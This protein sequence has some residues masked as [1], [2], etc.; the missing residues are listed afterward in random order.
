M[1]P[2]SPTPEQTAPPRPSTS[3][4][5][6]SN[7]RV[8][9]EPDP[10]VRTRKAAVEDTLAEVVLLMPVVQPGV[11]ASVNFAS[12]S[13]AKLLTLIQAAERP[14]GKEEL[15]NALAAAFGSPSLLNASFCFPGLRPRVVMKEHERKPNWSACTSCGSEA[16]H[17]TPSEKR[18]IRPSSCENA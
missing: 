17:E 1:L 3:Q 10:T 4:G 13:V 9:R 16:N 15:R 12:L 11:A 5:P 7:S 18:D 14:G 8:G 2:Q 6:H